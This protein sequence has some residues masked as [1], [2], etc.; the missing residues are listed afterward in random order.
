LLGL[1]PE[2][3]VTVRPGEALLVTAGATAARVRRLA[4]SLR[5][6]RVLRLV[7]A[8][9]LPDAG[10]VARHT[11]DARRL[12][13][14]GWGL[15]VDEWRALGTAPASVH[16]APPPGGLPAAAWPQ[17]VAV[18]DSLR[19]HGTLPGGG[20][21]T[22]RDA[23]GVLDS[24]VAGSDGRFAVGTRPRAVGRQ[25]FVLATHGGVAETLGVV[26]APPPRPRAL[27]L[28][29]A[30]SFEAAA[31]RDFLAGHG[32]AVAWRAGISRERARTEFIN[33]PATSL[34]PLRPRLLDEL[35]LVVADG[36]ALTDLAASERAA[37]LQAVRDSGVGLILLADAAAA[38]AR[39]LGFVATADTALPER[40]VRPRSAAGR[41]AASPVPAV[42]FKLH[43]T[44]GA[45]SVLWSATGDVLA[46]VRP[47]GSGKI[48]L[49]L[50]AAP[51]RWLRA[52]ERPQF[53]SYWATLL[54]AAV[55]RHDDWT[56]ESPPARVHQPL[57]IGVH[58]ASAVPL[59]VVVTPAGGRD[60]VFLEPHPLDP[61]RSTG[62]YW[63]REPGWH[64]LAGVPASEFYVVSAAAW[65]GLRAA[66]RL[67]ATAYWA[68]DAPA[69][70]PERAPAPQRRRWPLT[71][72]LGLFVAAAGVLW[73]ERRRAYIRPMP[74]T[75]VAVLLALLV[76]CAKSAEDRRDEV[77]LCS[78]VNSQADLIALCLVADHK[79]AE[80]QADSAARR[81]A[82]ELDSLRA[83]QDDSVW[84]ADS[85][86]HRAELRQCNRGTDDIR[87]CLLVRAGWPDARATRTADSL[88]QRNAQ[89]HG[90]AVRS[91]ARGRNPIASCLMLNYKWNARRALATEDS[92]RRAQ[93]R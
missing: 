23:G 68:A 88:W 25:L 61:G 40:L 22:L 75:A 28:T 14:V 72:W 30:P 79:W 34:A 10:F 15:D 74:R 85:S 33:R 60:T 11:G 53:A 6:E 35:D 2:R 80:A 71:W 13:V 51:S 42:S 93:M 54:A 24:A 64:A 29:G 66:R 37:L 58:S 32:A 21:I 8:D 38:A 62:R 26:V 27:L 20:V 4:D 69:A 55:Q 87:E 16:A 1:R 59:A 52:G 43:E 91:C 84:N 48:V 63:P 70:L 83:V 3:F 45:G 17:R 50:V 12:H 5:T 9:S 57:R 73:A 36:R 86:R 41:A 39:P 44:F 49:T 77:A 92:V 67:A 65:A 31:L 47:H 78:A 76:G 19:V 7:G 56:I 90:R 89:Q 81:R 82:Q 46:Q 18:G